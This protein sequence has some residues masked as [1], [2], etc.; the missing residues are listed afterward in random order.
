MLDEMT[1]ARLL[2]TWL[3]IL[4]A[5]IV[6]M[7]YNEDN[8]QKNNI[9]PSDALIIFGTSINTPKKY[10]AVVVLCICNSA[11]RAINTNI[12][13]PWIINNIQDI[14]IYYKVNTY[15]AYEITAIHATYGF[16]D[17]YFYM[18]I[19]LS[20]IDLFMVE[21]IVDLCTAILTTRYYLYIKSQLHSEETKK[22]ILT[23]QLDIDT[24][25]NVNR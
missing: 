25:D 23:S 6:F 9:G 24:M 16:V 22:Y 5:I 20:Q 4:M 15:H 12:I 19:L 21:M 1:I 8:I 13:Q 10:I 11:F 7:T 2:L 3:F 14:K 17:W 18:N